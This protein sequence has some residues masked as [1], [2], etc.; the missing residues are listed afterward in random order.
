M[1]R[2]VPIFSAR[3]P[4]VRYYLGGISNKRQRKAAA[5]RPAGNTA[6]LGEYE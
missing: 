3:L 6:V 1:K 2:N 4:T 5:P